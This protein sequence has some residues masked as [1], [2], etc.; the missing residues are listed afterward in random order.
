MR[1]A[2]F[3]FKGALKKTLLLLENQFLKKENDL[4]DAGALALIL[5]VHDHSH[6]SRH[7][8]LA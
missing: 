7:R 1:F 8:Q 5:L 2:T 6:R 3:P 4:A